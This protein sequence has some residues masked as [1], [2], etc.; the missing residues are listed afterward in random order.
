MD[1]FL[2]RDKLLKWTQDDKEI[3]KSP[4][5]TINTSVVRNPAKKKTPGFM[6]QFYQTYKGRNNTK[7][8][9]K[10]RN[11]EE[12]NSQLILWSQHHHD[13]WT[14]RGQY[15]QEKLKTNIPY[16]QDKKKNNL[17]RLSYWLKIINQDLVRLSQECKLV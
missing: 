11:W 7:S 12:N 17:K 8:C 4:I 14:R 1:K 16:E 10:L 15:I 3:L 9:N 2:V 6:S 13:T 5:S